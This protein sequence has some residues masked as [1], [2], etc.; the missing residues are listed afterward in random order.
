M[1]VTAAP[2]FLWPFAALWGLLTTILKLA[3]RLVLGLI[4]IV[5]MMA[6]VLVSMTVLGL[7]VG[8]PLAV[9]GFLLLVR[10]IF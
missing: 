4:A 3:G 2:W 5:L 10:A 7:P 1:S 9:A 8:L 6:G